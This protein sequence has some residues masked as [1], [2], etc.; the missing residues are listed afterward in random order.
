MHDY[1]SASFL[2]GFVNSAAG[3]QYEVVLSKHLVVDRT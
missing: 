2:F 3:L 1:L